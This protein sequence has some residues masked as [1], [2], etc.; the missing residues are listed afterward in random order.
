MSQL[1]K[2]TKKVRGATSKKGSVALDIIIG[3]V[4]FLAFAIII[5][6]ALKILSEVNDEIQGDD[7]INNVSKAASS[8]ITAQF[9]KYFDNAFLM[10]VI[11][12]WVAILVTSF[13][14]DTYP[15]FF[16]IS[17]VLLIFV[18]IIGMY[19]TNTYTEVVS[20]A[21]VG[22]FAD[23]LPKIN[24]IMDHLLLVLM[25]IGSSSALAL[26]SNSGGGL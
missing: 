15:V 7:S 5:V 6:F 19:M 10:M 23:S 4:M 2:K 18:F 9:P 3:A 17:F 13:F 8:S 20:E 21:G 11:L 24:W 16:I 26:Y 12:F 25:V 1:F 22:T 14:L